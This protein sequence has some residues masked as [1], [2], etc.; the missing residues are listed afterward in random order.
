[1]V[2]RLGEKML[3]NRHGVVKEAELGANRQAGHTERTMPQL[4]QTKRQ[5]M[6]EPSGAATDASKKPKNGVP[7]L[8][9]LLSFL[10]VFPSEIRRKAVGRE[11]TCWRDKIGGRSR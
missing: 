8:L 4:G 10:P 11:G 9:P 7:F 3:R 5:P 1:M 2:Y 6:G